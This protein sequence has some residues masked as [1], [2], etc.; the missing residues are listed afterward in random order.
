M[1]FNVIIFTTEKY[2]NELPIIKRKNN[3]LNNYGKEIE[4]QIDYLAYELGDINAYFSTTVNYE[5]IAYEFCVRFERPSNAHNKG[6]DRKTLAQTAYNY[7]VG[8]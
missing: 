1:F 2:I 6:I 5:Q 4:Q 8:K 3:L 7:F